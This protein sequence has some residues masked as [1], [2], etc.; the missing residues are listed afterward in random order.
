MLE[1]GNFKQN[2]Q[3]RYYYCVC[4]KRITLCN[5][6]CPYSSPSSSRFFCQPCPGLRNCKAVFLIFK[7]SQYGGS[8]R[9]VQLFRRYP[10]NNWYKNWNL[11]FQSSIFISIEICQ[12][13]MI[14]PTSRGVDSTETDQAVLVTS[15]GSQSGHHVMKVKLK[16]LYLHYNSSFGHQT[17]QDG[18]LLWWAFDQVVLRDHG[19]N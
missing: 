10:C 18:N 14:W 6:M 12:T 5:Y 13:E 17:W 2:I 4:V 16:T 7:N 15:S 1:K 11:H 3:S 9:W 19:T 8:R